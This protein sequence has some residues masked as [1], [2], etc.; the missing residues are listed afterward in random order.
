MFKVF[1]NAWKI[2]DLRKKMLYTLML[3]VVFRL[4]S[5]IP[6]PFVSAEALKSLVSGGDNLFSMYNIISGGAFENATIFAMSIT[7]YIN[8]SIMMQLLSVAIPALERKVKEGEEGRKFL[9]QWTRYLTV[10]LAMLQATGLYFGLSGAITSRGVF[11]YFVVTLTFTAGTA[12]LMWLGEQINEKGIGNG[13]SLLIFAGIVS[14]GPAVINSFIE[15]NKAGQLNIIT[16]ILVVLIVVLV[17]AAVVLMND[18]ERRIPVMYAK[19]VVGRKMYGG[20]NSNIPLKV[21]MAGVM[22]IIFANALLTIPTT[23]AM[24]ITPTYKG[25]DGY[26]YTRQPWSSIVSFLSSSSWFYALLTFVLILAFAYFYVSISFNPFEVSG[27]IQ[28]NGGAIPG[29]RPGRATAMFIKKV[30][31][32]VTFI[33]ALSLSVICVIPLVINI[34]IVA[35]GDV[36]VAFQAF[37]L[38]GELATCGTSVVIV[39][40]VIIETV[41]EIESQLTM[42]HYKGFLD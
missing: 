24:F 8:A 25:A 7:P 12:F 16:T 28:K 21:N 32:K 41:R 38:V 33:G 14:R 42:R 19:R 18:S 15:M 9:A 36:N 2:A 27:N 20:Q 10:V 22:P 13:I 39:V 1:A 6:V 26:T 4:G 17:V 31:S 11:T 35:L 37:G 34:I 3:I 29:I 23:I 30:L 40:G 5:S